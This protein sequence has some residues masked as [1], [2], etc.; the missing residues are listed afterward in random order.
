MNNLKSLLDPNRYRKIEV[1]DKK[2]RPINTRFEQAREFGNYVG[3]NTILVLR[4]FKIYGMGEVLSI[5]SWL[6]D[7]P[8]DNKK[9]GKFTLAIWKLKDNKGL[10]KK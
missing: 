7:C 6:A 5:R 8:Y 2:Q 1:G 9:G 4:L 10:N 3:I